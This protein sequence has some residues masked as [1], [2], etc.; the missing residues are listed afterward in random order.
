MAVARLCPLNE[1][2]EAKILKYIEYPHCL[3]IHSIHLWALPH[4]VCLHGRIRGSFVHRQMPIARRGPPVPGSRPVMSDDLSTGMVKTA[5]PFGSLVLFFFFFCLLFPGRALLHLPLRPVSRTEVGSARLIFCLVRLAG[6]LLFHLYIS[7][8][9]CGWNLNAARQRLASTLCCN[10]SRLR[11]PGPTPPSQAVSRRHNFTSGR[12][13]ASSPP[14]SNPSG[15]EP[16]AFHG[17]SPTLPPN[18]FSRFGSMAR[19][20]GSGFCMT[21]DATFKRTTHGAMSARPF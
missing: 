9:G 21:I 18:P 20:P 6:A 1:K 5:R 15:T 19:F 13:A 17:G 2:D 12:I 10:A 14:S 7:L 16:T 4:S 11:S 3:A 8:E